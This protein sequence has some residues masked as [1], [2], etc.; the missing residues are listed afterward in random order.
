VDSRYKGGRGIEVPMESATAPDFAALDAVICRRQHELKS[1]LLESIGD[2]ILAH[3]LEG[4]IIYANHRAAEMLGYDHEELLALP[5][6]GW[7]ADDIRSRL[8]KRIRQIRETSG[9]VYETLCKG[10][11]GQV[12]CVEVGSRMV[13]VE[14]WGQLIVSVA[15]D[16]AERSAAHETMHRLAF[17]DT[18][19][20]LSNRVMLEDRIAAALSGQPLHGRTVGLIYMDLDDFKPINDTHGHS[21]GDRVLCI[22]AERMLNSVRDSDTI[23]RVGGDEFIAL[24]PRLSNR[25]ELGAKARSIAECVSQPIA[26]DDM[27]V[28]VSV[29]VGLATYVPGEEHDELITRAD[30]AMYRAKLNGRAG[31]EEFL[32]SA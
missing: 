11:D 1:L 21:V 5:P 7:L 18:L 23:A 16:M 19:T 2:G 30:H 13:A 4:R 29:S 9:E 24:F 26:L 14:P 28:R 10:R 22:I 6:W 12:F 31:W 15:R 3:T 20:G 27:I 17:Y 25:M 8:S 32:A